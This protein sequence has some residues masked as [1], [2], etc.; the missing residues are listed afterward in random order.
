MRWGNKYVKILELFFLKLFKLL[1]NFKT[2][3]YN[4]N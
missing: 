1:D 2:N 3:E 4:L